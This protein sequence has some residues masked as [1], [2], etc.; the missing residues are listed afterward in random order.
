MSAL[1]IVV[2]VIALIM[3]SVAA[4]GYQ[5]A[6]DDAKKKRVYTGVGIF[7]LIL[8]IGGVIMMMMGGSDTKNAEVDANIPNNP[9]DLQ[10]GMFKMEATLDRWRAKAGRIKANLNEK[11]G[12]L[13]DR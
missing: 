12:Y 2:L 10:Q 6:K 1:A 8:G 13:N 4:W 7:G 9:K 5:S 11:A 3:S